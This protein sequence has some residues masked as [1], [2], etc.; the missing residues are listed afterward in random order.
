MN[1]NGIVTLTSV[2]WPAGWNG[3]LPFDSEFQNG[4]PSCR[5]HTAFNMCSHTQLHAHAH[6]HTHTHVRTHT[7]TQ[8]CTH[9][10][11]SSHTHTHTPTQTNTYLLLQLF[12]P[13]CF[14]C[15]FPSSPKAAFTYSTHTFTF[16]HAHTFTWHCNGWVSRMKTL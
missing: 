8:T 16:T 2:V 4:C 6:S 14:F 3:H 9:T 10:Y 12:F 1:T 7:R 11:A 15:Q 5:P 13:M